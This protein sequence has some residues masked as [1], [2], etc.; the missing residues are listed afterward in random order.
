M[1]REKL[2]EISRLVDGA[3]VS[4]DV[5][6]GGDDAGA[7]VYGRVYSV[8]EDDTSGTGFTLLAELVEDNRQLYLRE[9]LARYLYAAA[10]PGPRMRRALEVEWDAGRAEP[11]GKA[12]SYA[13]ADEILAV[14]AGAGG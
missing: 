4:V 1:D 14:L 7:R 5:S 11:R 10:F 2:A 6:I 8:Q 12:A 13:R 3:M 9:R